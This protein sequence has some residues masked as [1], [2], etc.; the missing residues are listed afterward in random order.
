MCPDGR[1]QHSEA[2]HQ[3]G[4]DVG[5]G[6]GRVAERVDE[7]S[8]RVAQVVQVGAGGASGLHRGRGRTDG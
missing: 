8:Q 3:R 2:R 6:L 1:Q 4:K 5:A 7:G